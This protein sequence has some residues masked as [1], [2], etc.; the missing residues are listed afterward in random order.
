M[1]LTEFIYFS[2]SVKRRLDGYFFSSPSFTQRTTPSKFDT[3]P[4][5]ISLSNEI[6]YQLTFDEDSTDSG[7]QNFNDLIVT[8]PFK[9]IV[10][11]CF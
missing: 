2:S 3:N 9:T 6:K 4:F 5:E 7:F 1:V 11:K 10:S 8:T